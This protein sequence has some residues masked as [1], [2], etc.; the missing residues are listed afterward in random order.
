[1]ENNFILDLI[2]CLQKGESRKQ[3]NSDIKNIEKTLNMLR[4]TGTFAKGETKKELNAYIKQL[5]NQ[6]STIKLK[7]KIDSKNL[8]SEVDKA[9]NSISFKDIDALNID[10]NK[11]K[12]KVKKIIA[13]TKTFVEK[14][15]VS[16]GINIESKKNKLG[17]DL[18]AYLNRNTKINESSILL[19]EAD[20]V[21]DLISAINDKKS[22]REATDAFQ[23]Y[24]SEVS[25]TGYATKSTADRIKSMFGHITKLGSLFSVASLAANNFT[26]SLGTLKEIDDILTEIS[27]TSD[28]TAQ[29]LEKLGNI[30]FKS[31]SKYGKTAS[32]YL[33]GIQEMSRSGFYGEKGTAMAEQSLL[34]QAAGDMSAD[35]ANNYILATNAAYKLN[36][37]A[38]KINAVLDGQNSITNRNSVAMSDMAAAMSKAGTV[39]SSYRVSVEDLSAMIGTIESVTKAEGGEVGN[40][41]KA[42]LINLQN[43]TSSKIKDTLDAANASMTEFVNDTEKLR[44]PI[45]ILRDLA[46]TFNK[47]DEDDALRAEILTNIGGKHQATKLAALLQNMELF[48]KM[49][50]DYS[51]G[52]GSAMEE[53]MKSANNWSGKLNQLQNSWD[54]LV[55]SIINKDT[56]LSGLTFGDKLIRGAESLVNT[57]GE[58]PV[59]LTTI[60]AAMTA[61]QKDY[62]ITKVWDK[63]NLTRPRQNRHLKR[64]DSIRFLVFL[65][66]S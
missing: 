20:K 26:K 47:L 6:L 11:T 52:A 53:A 4:L 13:D 57:V 9:L 12:L 31:A 44:D 19:K 23:L 56:V 18:T 1:M 60:N 45:S 27:K 16:L 8:K 7:A 34:A 63:E 54:S 39:A 21:R 43:I 2:A 48:D 41:I 24:K 33:T 40:G 10:E 37:E 25:A 5:S 59:L 66:F 28:L 36:G 29:Q 42:I 65:T 49:L 3:L 51:E 62:G 15:P 14:N 58:I 50:V 38:E 17:N 32:D 64:K 55:N 61:M 22:L 30:S 35:L 46:D